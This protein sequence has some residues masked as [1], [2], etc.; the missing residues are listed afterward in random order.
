[1]Q[2]MGESDKQV[3]EYWNTRQTNTLVTG[4][5]SSRSS[6]PAFGSSVEVFTLPFRLQWKDVVVCKQYMK[7]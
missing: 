4:I 5:W 1:M 6:L 7:I 3:Q 2:K